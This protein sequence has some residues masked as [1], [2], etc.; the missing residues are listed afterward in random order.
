MIEYPH[1]ICIEIDTREK[2][3]LLFPTFIHVDPGDRTGT[4]R[5]AIRTAHKALKT[6]DYR[7]ASAPNSCVIERKGSQLELIKNLFDLKDTTR[8]AR[9]I[10]RLSCCCKHPYLLIEVSPLQMIANN[11]LL[12]PPDLLLNRLARLALHFNL[13]VLWAPTTTS[14]N[15]RRA[16]GTAVAH[17]LVASAF[18]SKENTDAVD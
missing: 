2:R 3:P 7:L 10:K 6:G 4:K 8:V 16:V 13:Q 1:D 9:S 11:Q 15:S 5:I 14:N 18:C 12:D 17:L